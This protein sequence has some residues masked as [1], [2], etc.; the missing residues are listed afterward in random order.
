M[1]THDYH[2]TL[3][4][5]A[6]QCESEEFVQLMSTLCT[7][8]GNRIQIG[9]H[10]LHHRSWSAWPKDAEAFSRDLSKSVSILEHHFP[11]HFKP[12]FRAPAGYIASWMIPVLV[13][14]GF[15]VDSSINPSWLV[16]KK[17]G[18]G[19]SWKTVQSTVKESKIVERQWKN[20]F[21]LTDVRSCST[22]HRLTMEC[23]KGL[24][25]IEKTALNQ[26]D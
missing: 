1:R 18:K 12:W 5:I 16:S 10:G 13:E 22:H 4:V 19:E 15:V 8:F 9:C 7:E 2:L 11:Q 26:R 3:F 6:D 21:L 17:Y 24:E 23:K 20:S 14:H 25:P